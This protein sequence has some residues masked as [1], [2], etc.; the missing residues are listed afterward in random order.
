MEQ[1]MECAM[2]LWVGALH[3]YSL[4]IMLFGEKCKHIRKYLLTF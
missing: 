3:I 2:K 4:V 1:E